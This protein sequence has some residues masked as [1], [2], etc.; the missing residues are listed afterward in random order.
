MK[1]IKI[2]LMI[3]FDILNYRLKNKSHIDMILT[4]LFVVCCLLL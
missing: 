1:K 3:P 2:N 4:Y